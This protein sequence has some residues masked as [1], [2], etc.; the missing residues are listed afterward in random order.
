MHNTHGTRTHRHPALWLAATV[1]SLCILMISLS[2]CGPSAEELAAV[3]YAPLPGDDWEV[4]TP[5]EQGTDP[6]L[7]AGLYLDA[8]DVETLKSLLVIKN[9]Y[10]IAEQYYHNGSIDEK[11]RLQS[12]TKSVVS[13][14]A[15]I[16]LD[17]G[18]IPSVDERALDYLPESAQGISDPRKRD[19]T[20]RQ[21]LQ[22]RAGFPWE[23]S[24]QA[25]FELLYHG[26]KPSLF[27][28]IPL[29]YDPGTDME[30]SNLTAHLVG[31]TVAQTTD[32]D[33]LSFGEAHLFGPMGIEPG[34][35]TKDWKG[36]YNGH[37][38]LHMRA[39]DMAKI[40]LLYL[41]DGQYGGRQIV[42]AG[43]V[44]D[45]LA[46]Y[47]EHAAQYR[48][49]PGYQDIGYGYLWWNARAGSRRFNF[50]WGHGG[51]QITLV[52]D[53]DMV[54][55]VTADPLHGQHGDLPWKREKENLNLVGDFIRSLPVQ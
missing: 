19:I 5:A 17:Q 21:M 26:F 34:R 8:E 32:T 52:D 28:D 14:L 23:E 22:M 53:M 3:E 20:I 10:L 36:Y 30:Y 4:S 51:Q 15:G 33:L 44:R 1:L 12:V 6:A 39:R 50:A 49:G 2:G 38:D 35:W 9:G 47:T 18:Y 43:W 11:A 13:A 37:A 45:S 31:I 16:A 46:T 54:I 24:S 27:A 7:I 55:V 41:N 40:G 25:L 48:V 42:S 29:V